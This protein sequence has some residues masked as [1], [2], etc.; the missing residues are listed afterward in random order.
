MQTTDGNVMTIDNTDYTQNPT[1][2][3][4]ENTQAHDDYAEDH[5]AQES[6]PEA[7][8]EQHE[9]D[10]PPDP[11]HDDAAAWKNRYYRDKR[12][13]ERELNDLKKQLGSISG[14]SQ[15]NSYQ[16][17]AQ[18]LGYGQG[19]YP[20]HG[21]EQPLVD[22][23]DGSVLEPGSVRY[24]AV[25][26]TLGMQALTQSQAQQREQQRLQQIQNQHK[27]RYEKRVSDFA[28]RHYD[29][30]DYVNDYA[31]PE[32]VRDT[33]EFLPNGPDVL[34]DLAKNN[35]RELERIK[36]LDPMTQREAVIH[37]AFN[38][39][40]S[41][42]RAFS[43]APPPTGHSTNQRSYSSTDTDSYRSLKEAAMRKNRGE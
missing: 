18:G 23:I 2:D 4:G 39:K 33:A 12:K 42:G 3:A 10:A 13:L 11:Q 17:G 37:Y 29:F 31:V 36:S 26:S 40:G 41:G 6:A 25:R 34:Y 28:S 30:D 1:P 38:K 32:I 22:P 21:Y 24:E 15:K 35:P 5:G 43:K 19:S 8:Q 20:A 7:N 14:Q 16:A 27:S 9:T